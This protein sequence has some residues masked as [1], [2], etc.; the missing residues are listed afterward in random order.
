MS[1]NPPP[2]LE[3]G[4]PLTERVPARRG[5]PLL[6][7]LAAI[8]TVGV[9]VAQPWN[10][11]SPRP[12]PVA[13]A[14]PSPT[15][16]PTPTVTPAPTPPPTLPPPILPPADLGP[17]DAPGAVALGSAAG[18]PVVMC[19]YGRVRRGV[20]RLV[21][22]E[23][24]PPIVTLNDESSP[25][26]ITQVAWRFELEMNQQQGVFDRNWQK[27]GTSRS[28]AAGTAR[29]RPAPF[30][31]LALRPRT[32]DANATA[33]YRVRVIVAWFTRNLEPAG[34][35][36]LLAAPYQAADAQP[37]DPPLPYCAAVLRSS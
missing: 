34:E 9:L 37:S 12:S 31:A 29:D 28:Q 11:R 1:V 13:A 17:V 23:V 2:D 24:L 15:A 6:V 25:I 16:A 35:I 33:V 10:D 26:D 3:P 27:V 22:I 19:D 30:S 5:V 32:Q 20:R 8:A 36:E 21:E 18:A 4:V 14:T 7:A